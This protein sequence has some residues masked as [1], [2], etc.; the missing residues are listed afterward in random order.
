MKK[1]LITFALLA[2]F[3]SSSFA[4]TVAVTIAPGGF[5]NIVSVVG[6][7]KVTQ[8]VLASA[9][10]TSASVAIYDCSGSQTYTNA[11]YI[12]TTTYS[13]NLTYLYTN[14]FGV[15]TTNTGSSPY[16]LTNKYTA[17]VD[18]TNTVAASTNFYPVK[19]SF[20]SPTNATTVLG[21]VNYYFT[22]GVWATNT[23]TSG[24]AI[25]TVTFQ[26]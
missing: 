5:S 4:S 21:N 23:A 16:G 17:I 10:T 2:G 15:S 25:L 8:I 9:P 18:V 7:A 26:Q 20:S 19:I 6:I 11:A 13:T 24:N 1:I 14:Y 12:A 22:Q 3:A